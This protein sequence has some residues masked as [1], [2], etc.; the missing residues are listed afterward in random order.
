V[1]D[2]VGMFFGTTKIMIISSPYVIILPAD[3]HHEPTIRAAALCIS[4]SSP[5]TSPIATPSSPRSSRSHPRP[6]DHPLFTAS[7]NSRLNMPTWSSRVAAGNN[8]RDDGEL[9]SP[10]HAFASIASRSRTA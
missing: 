2:T 4:T 9:G 8:E 7:S 5:V 10:A 3:E 1:A 6:D